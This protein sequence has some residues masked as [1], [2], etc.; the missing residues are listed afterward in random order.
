MMQE[1]RSAVT[2]AIGG[3][4]NVMSFLL[5]QFEK[6]LKHKHLELQLSEAKLAQQMAAAAEEKENS[7]S[8]RQYVSH[9]LITSLS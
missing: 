7:Q 8:E 9:L 3:A 6:L 1:K 5:Q 2:V 4:N